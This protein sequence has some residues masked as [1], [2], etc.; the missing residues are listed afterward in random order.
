MSIREDFEAWAGSVGYPLTKT[1]LNS[2][3]FA[4]GETTAAWKVWQAATSLREARIKAL[5]EALEELDEEWRELNTAEFGMQG[6]ET[7]A[8]YSLPS[9]ITALAAS[10][11]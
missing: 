8:F 6:E 9:T 5:V 2:S 1:E 3:G 10:K 11:E 4:Y 7:N